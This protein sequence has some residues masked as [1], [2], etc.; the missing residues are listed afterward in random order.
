MKT[1]KILTL[2]FLCSIVFMN[3]IYAQK[4][5]VININKDTIFCK[6]RTNGF[7]G[8]LQYR[9]NKNDNFTNIKTDSI[10]QFYLSR[11]TSTFILKKLPGDTT[12]NYIQWLER[13]RINLY[14]IQISSYNSGGGTSYT[15]YASKGNDSLIQIK[16]EFKRQGSHKDRVSAFMNLISDNPKLLNW[17]KE[18]MEDV[19]DSFDIIRACIKTYNK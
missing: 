16:A 17:F 18:N 8:R 9:A 2:I 10:I 11:D 15:W 12:K 19:G 6:I 14:G 7:N 13:G 3:K 1:L 4:D 5:Y